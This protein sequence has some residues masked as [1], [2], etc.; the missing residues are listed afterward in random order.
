M[1]TRWTAITIPLFTALCAATAPADGL[2]CQLPEDGAW[3]RF[4]V[5]GTRGPVGG[6]QLST[7]GSL[8]MASVGRS[9]AADEDCRWIEF[10]YEITGQY[11][12][13]F[14]AKVLIPEKYLANDNN[15]LDHIV[16]GW[17]RFD[18]NE[19]E[20]V[21][22][23]AAAPYLLSDW[24]GGPLDEVE[25]LDA[26]TLESKLGPLKCEGLTGFTETV[27]DQFEVK[28]SFETRLHDKAPFGVVTSRVWS[29][30]QAGGQT[31]LTTDEFFT[32]AALGN[33]AVSA[34]P[35]HD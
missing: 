23:N 3:V 7:T 32:L 35:D 14:T 22:Q 29:E 6:P 4:D 24:L 33:D 27:R 10:E 15:P 9:R 17:A 21:N 2:F 12:L 16:R 1:L 18:D 26:V 19:P 31:A 34:L 11:E 20:D 8:T 5:K 25:K 28:T 30:Y 13:K